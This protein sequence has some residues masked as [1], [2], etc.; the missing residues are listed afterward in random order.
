MLLPD[1]ERCADGGQ[2][3][4]TVARRLLR[5]FSA[6]A[7]AAADRV[8]SPYRDVPPEYYRFPWF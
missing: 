2:E 6:V 1:P 3:E 5:L 7:L 8:T 4:Q